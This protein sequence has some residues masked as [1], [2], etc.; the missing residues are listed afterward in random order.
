MDAQFQCFNREFELSKIQLKVVF[1]C[2]RALVLHYYLLRR[3]LVMWNW[4]LGLLHSLSQIIIVHLLVKYWWHLIKASMRTEWPFPGRLI[5]KY[6]HF[7]DI[8]SICSLLNSCLIIFRKLLRF[9]HF[10]SF[11]AF[12]GPTALGWVVLQSRALRACSHAS[13]Q[14]TIPS[15]QPTFISSFHQHVVEPIGFG[16]K[17]TPWL[18]LNVFSFV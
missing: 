5:E 7:T 10:H 17:R 6:I 13:D 8:P 12:S 15:S 1:I 11:P 18:G 3:H 2:L 14:Y 4:N 16:G 9:S